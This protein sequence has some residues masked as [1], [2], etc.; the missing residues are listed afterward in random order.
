MGTL[1]VAATL[2]RLAN[3]ANVR[4]A[5]ST[6][7]RIDAT[8]DYSGTYATTTYSITLWKTRRYR[9][10]NMAK[11][12]ETAPDNVVEDVLWTEKYRPT[13]LPDLALDSDN[14]AI[15]TAYLKAGEIPHLLL[16]GPPGTG[17]TTVARILYRSLDCK[18]LV[19][20][21]SKDRGI[22]VVRNKI[23]TFI[24]TITDARW[25]VPFL[26]EADALTA[27]AQTALRN[28]IEAHADRARFIFTANKLHKIIGAIQDR[29]QVL[30]FGPP[31]LKERYRIL[32]KV[33]EAEGIAAGVPIIMGYAERYLSLRR[34]LFAAQRMYLAR[35]ELAPV[36]ADGAVDGPSILELLLAKN[37]TGLRRLTTN[38]SFDPQQNLRELFWAIPDEHARAGFLRH[39]IGKGVHETAFTPDPVILFLGV[40]AEAMEGL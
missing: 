28:M 13:K 2:L 8:Q 15:L 29:C 17:K 30:T 18:H 11:A 14:R 37:W 10:R 26:D 7:E 40:C 24:T 1:A 39:I 38:D 9:R 20:N 36:Q 23:G 27:D 25:N 31:P 16:V 34:L 5:A 19:L 21:A 4:A 22:D 35:G 32:A 3:G 12:K 33:L 6:T